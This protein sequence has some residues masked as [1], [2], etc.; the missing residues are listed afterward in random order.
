M[1]NKLQEL[2]DRLY[3]EG[4]SK[5]KQEGDQI[6]ADAKE[7]AAKIVADAKEQAQAIIDAARKQAE[8]IK[9]KV[10]SDVKMASREAVNVTK[11]DIE[12]L[13]VTGV[14]A[15]ATSKALSDVEFAKGV[16]TAVAQAFST[17]Q[18]ADIELVLPESQ[19]AELE[20][21]VKGQLA[22]ILGKGVEASFSKKIAGGFTIA[23]KDGGYFISLCEE[24][25]NELICEYLRPATRKILFG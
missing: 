7:Q 23:P 14:S 5:G 4:L 12:K 16:I 13:I 21:F 9:A 24:T 8:D 19:K 15:E 1:T 10:T 17:Q 20:P 22:Q 25:F 18:S 3:N 11:Q 6:L 2:T